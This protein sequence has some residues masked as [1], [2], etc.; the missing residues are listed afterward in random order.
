M[1]LESFE[2]TMFYISSDMYFNNSTS[3]LT[4]PALD[5]Q[6]KYIHF[7]SL[8]YSASSFNGQ[9]APLYRVYL[10]RYKNAI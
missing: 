8:H 4:H 3:V 5:M 6:S 10:K 7:E 9:E 2:S 1:R